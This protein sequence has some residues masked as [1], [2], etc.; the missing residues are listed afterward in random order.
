MLDLGRSEAELWAD[1]GGKRRNGIR[2]ARKHG[3]VARHAT[4]SDLEACTRVWIDGYC[5]KFR[6]PTDDI[7]PRVRGW[8]ERGRLLLAQL[9]SDGPVIANVV[10]RDGYEASE[11]CRYFQPG[12]YAVYSANSSLVDYQRYKPNELLVWEAVLCLKAMGFREFV[13]GRSGVRFKGQFS[14]RRVT[15]DY[16]V[17][18]RGV[19]RLVDIVA[20]G[21]S[22]FIEKARLRS[23]NRRQDAG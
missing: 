3:V 15:V 2:Y 7:L 23:R 10:Y 8:I 6:H 18:N 19:K 13:I 21:L 1:L 5:A 20:I 9:G 4:L 11:T 22:S 14:S 16:W 17:R 12:I